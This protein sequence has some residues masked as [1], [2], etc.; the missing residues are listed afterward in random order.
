[1]R[2][3]A[4]RPVPVDDLLEVQATGAAIVGHLAGRGWTAE[5]ASAHVWKGQ[6]PRDI[7]GARVR[8]DLEAAGAWGKVALP[9]RA[10]YLNDA[11]HAV[12]LGWW[13][14]ARQRR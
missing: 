2:H 8:E 9:T 7:F 4:H 5:G 3:D 6:V 14:L 12:G 1:M 11:M 13:A 10:T